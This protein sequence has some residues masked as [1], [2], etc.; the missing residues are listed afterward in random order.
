MCLPVLKVLVPR[1]QIIEFLNVLSRTL[2]KIRRI[3]DLHCF[4]EVVE[5]VLPFA[6]CVFFSPVLDLCEVAAGMRRCK[7]REDSFPGWYID[8][9]RDGRNIAVAHE[10]LPNRVDAMVP[11]PEHVRVTV[12]GPVFREF[13]AFQ[14][15]FRKPLWKDDPVLR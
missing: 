7:T 3:Y 6:D 14:A 9:E 8:V 12:N 1:E 13:E 10:C 4:L 15:V 5:L 2:V 11:M